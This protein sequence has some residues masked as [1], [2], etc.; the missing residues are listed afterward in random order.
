[1]TKCV[2]HAPG[3]RWI[4]SQVSETRTRLNDALIRV[5]RNCNYRFAV[6]S[7]SGALLSRA[8]QKTGCHADRV[9]GDMRP[10]LRHM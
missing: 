5:S 4:G 6:R 3:P 10:G 1:M 2:A 7:F 9:D 8:D